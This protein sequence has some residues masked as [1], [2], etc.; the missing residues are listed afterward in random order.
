MAVSTSSD[1]TGFFSDLFEQAMFVLRESNLMANLVTGFTGMGMAPRTQGIYPEISAQEV[2]EGVDFATGTSWNKSSKMSLTPA[3]NKAQVIITQSMM[4]TDPD[5]T[6]NDAADE[7]GRAI[8]TKVDTD[9]VGN[10]SSFTNDLGTAGSALTIARCAAAM[11]RLNNAKARAPFYYVVHPYG[12]YDIWVELGQPAAEKA[13]LGDVA[14]EALRDY[15][16][17]SFNNATW[18]TNA[19]ISVNSS[20]D[21]AVSAVFNPGALALDVRQ[22]PTMAVDEDPSIAGYGYEI[23]VET[24]YAHGIRRNELGAALTHDATAPT[25]T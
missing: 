8:A 2:G 21:D 9:L 18:F 25:G 4:D 11:A 12:W 17:A 13:F 24:W 3:I 15:Q 23:N 6:M 22:V 5:D 1:L 20:T 10:F 14:N 16:V 7:L 19:N